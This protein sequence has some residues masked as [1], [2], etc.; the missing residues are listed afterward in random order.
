MVMFILHENFRGWTVKYHLR[1][2]GI[3]GVFMYAGMVIIFIMT[4]R[5]GESVAKTSA[6]AD[7]VFI[8]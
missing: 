6:T 8:R 2:A 5:A 1:Y 4:A 7:I 3:G